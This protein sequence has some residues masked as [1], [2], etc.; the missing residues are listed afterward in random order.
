MGFLLHTG[1]ASAPADIKIERV[2]QWGGA[3]KAV[4]VVGDRA[5]LGVGPRLSVLDISDPARPVELGRTAGVFAG[6]VREVVVSGDYAYVSAGTLRIVDVSNPAAPL[7][8][9]EYVG[10]DD[11]IENEFKA[12]IRGLVVSGNYV[13]VGY[14][15]DH[16]LH[17]VDVSNPKSPL[18]VGAVGVIA[19]RR[20]IVSGDFAFLM[21]GVGLVI[22]DVSDPT[23]PFE[24]HRRY[25]SGEELDMAHSG[26]LLYVLNEV[27]SIRSIEYIDVSDPAAPQ[28]VAT[29][30]AGVWA[31]R[32]H[33][34]AGRAMLVHADGLDIYDVSIPQNF[35]TFLG[36]FFQTDRRYN[37]G[38]LGYSGGHVLLPLIQGGLRTVDVSDPAT[39]TSVGVYETPGGIGDL[40]VSGSYAY[41]GGTMPDLRILDISDPAQPTQVAEFRLQEPGGGGVTI[42]GPILYLGTRRA[43]H[44]LSIADPVAPEH[45]ASVELPAWATSL[46]MAGQYLFVVFRQDGI[47]ILDVSDPQ[48][49]LQIGSYN[50]GSTLTGVGI[51]GSAAFLFHSGST[52]V[53]VLDISDLTAPF[54]MGYFYAVGPGGW[55][56]MTIRGNLA[57][58]SNGTPGMSIIDISDPLA[59]R[60]LGRHNAPRTSR[61]HKL[62]G[63]LAYLAGMA[64]GLEIVDVSRPTAPA[65][66]ARHDTFDRASQVT[67][68]GSY[69]FVSDSWGGLVIFRTTFP[70]DMNCD[71]RFNGADI[72]PFFLALGDPPAY[73]ARFPN[74]NILNGDMNGDGALNGAD[75]D[76]FFQLLGGG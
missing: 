52:L 32:I 75:L 50:D 6:V 64:G 51:S 53:K 73:A 46:T 15:P 48:A 69:A 49:P 54:R 34:R 37:E 1:V 68:S 29:H 44:V 3:T 9:G 47:M 21:A 26:H 42:D 62:V 57:Y 13:Y 41:V 7:I 5:Y 10:P 43:L 14:D 55:S 33:V 16:T 24:I 71:G 40:A 70:G 60:W 61:N 20:V 58:V 76:P 30:R 19:I 22:I 17:I 11:E 27:V 39:P 31:A 67:V 38:A 66:I 12:H 4:A 65:L 28:T 8:V 2:A 72:D 35:P 59:P 18:R 56:R 23:A 74:C 45:W 36:G 63:E 25:L